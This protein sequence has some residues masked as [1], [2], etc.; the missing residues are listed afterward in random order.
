MSNQKKQIAAALLGFRLLL[1][2]RTIGEGLLLLE[3]LGVQNDK[4]LLMGESVPLENGSRMRTLPRWLAS[5]P[6]L[7][8]ALL[9]SET[10][11]Y[12]GGPPNNKH[13]RCT[14][15]AGFVTDR[16]LSAMVEKGY[17][18]ILETVSEVLGIKA[19]P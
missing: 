14:T 8:L 4:F 1:A 13:L 7:A 15:L 12:R 3:R 5:R 11:K 10:I 9:S 2:N 19:A 6:A 18:P 17:E 16:L